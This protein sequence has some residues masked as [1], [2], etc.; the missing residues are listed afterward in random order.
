MTPVVIVISPLTLRSWTVAKI[1]ALGNQGQT[2][3]DGGQRQQG[4]R[5][6]NKLYLDTGALRRTWRLVPVHHLV[7]RLA[8]PGPR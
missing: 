5:R 6:E 3:A 7:T 8:G 4:T 1:T 2:K